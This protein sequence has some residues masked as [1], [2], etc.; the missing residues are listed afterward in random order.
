MWSVFVRV[1]SGAS[2][3]HSQSFV[4]YCSM[5]APMKPL[6]ARRLIGTPPMRR[7]SPRTGQRKIESLPIQL[8]CRPVP[9]RYSNPRM[10]S[11][12]EVCG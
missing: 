3:S 8:A 7:N 6:A 11:Q 9:K 2:A 4:L 1:P 10:K 5:A 12:L